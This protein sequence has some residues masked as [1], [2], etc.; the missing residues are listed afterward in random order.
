LRHAFGALQSAA[1]MLP[2]A[3]DSPSVWPALARQI[4]ESRR[5]APGF[6]F[7]W[8]FSWSRLRLWPTLGLSMGLLVSLGFTIAIRDQT[9]QR[10]ADLARTSKQPIESRDTVLAVLEPTTPAGASVHQPEPAPE[11][12][13]AP[14][15]DYDLERGTPMG[16]ESSEVKS[17]L[18]H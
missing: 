4:R 10:Q 17:K 2:V 18:T 15:F 12:A 1:Q 3:T 13:A 8:A 11:A 9:R 14:R 5:P 16:P 6:T 7:P